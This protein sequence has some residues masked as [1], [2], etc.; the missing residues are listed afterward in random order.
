MNGKWKDGSSLTYGGRGCGLLSVAYNTGIGATVDTASFMYPG[1]NDLAGRVNWTEETSG[2][3]PTDII[4]LNSTNMFSFKP[5]EK[6][7]I[8]YATLHT[9]A[10][11]NNWKSQMAKD[12]AIVKRWYKDNSFPSC[13]RNSIGINDKLNTNSNSKIRLNRHY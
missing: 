6:K 2:N 11:R 7:T 8:E 9:R 10:N 13:G 12:I 5:G 1:S 3:K 4:C